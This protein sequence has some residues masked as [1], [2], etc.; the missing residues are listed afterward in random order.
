MKGIITPV[1]TTEIMM[2]EET[3]VE[4]K[5]KN[6]SPTNTETK[7]ITEAGKPLIEEIRD[8]IIGGPDLQKIADIEEFLAI[9]EMRS[10]LE[11]QIRAIKIPTAE[12]NK[13][14]GIIP[15]TIEEYSI[16]D[17]SETKNPTLPTTEIPETL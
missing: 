6:K 1:K 8:T 4:E 11:D 9:L 13:T 16:T 17:I 3:P 15:I 2:K 7:D 12:E 14:T 10:Y 5:M